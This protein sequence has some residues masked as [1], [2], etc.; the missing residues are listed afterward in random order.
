M[1]D[2]LTT[3][4]VS[5]SSNRT[6]R[7]A[8]EGMIAGLIGATVIAVWFLILD[9]IQDR[10]LYTPTLLGTAL[11]RGGQGLSQGETIPISLE[12]TLKFTWVH[13]MV[14][15]II[16][17]GVSWFLE[18]AERNSNLGFGILLLFVVLEFGFIIATLLFAEPILQSLAWP[19][20][21]TGNLLA[22]A[23]MSVYFWYRHPN[24][25][26]RP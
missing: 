1:T 14:F 3:T 4:D 17:G 20:V 12:M 19:A 9:T 13:G 8:V 16:G 7:L 5:L 10:P 26:I 6:N 23:A 11:F 18:L 24:L 21:F 22:A 2:R 25:T 15:M